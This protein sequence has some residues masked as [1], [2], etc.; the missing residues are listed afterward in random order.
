M[1][2]IIVDAC[3]K[4]TLCVDACPNDC[5]HPTKAEAGFEAAP[6][7]YINPDECLDCGACVTACTANAIF[8]ALGNRQRVCLGDFQNC[9]RILPWS[10]P[11]VFLCGSSALVR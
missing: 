7:L 10:L 4:L 1:A 8:P 9:A 5:I 11:G 2:H 6:Q 3:T